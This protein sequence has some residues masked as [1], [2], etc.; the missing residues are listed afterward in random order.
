MNCRDAPISSSPPVQLPSH[1]R[2]KQTHKVEDQSRKPS[3]VRDHAPVRLVHPNRIAVGRLARRCETPLECD[4]GEDREE[5]PEDSY[6]HRAREAGPR[7]EGRLG[8]VGRAVAVVGGDG[9][10]PERRDEGAAGEE[11]EEGDAEAGRAEQVGEVSFRSIGE[12]V[13]QGNAPSNVEGTVALDKAVVGARED[14]IEEGAVE[15]EPGSE[16]LEAIEVA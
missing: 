6:E 12:D 8:L 3:K 15:D 16:E 5:E 1:K 14:G 2:R 9:D 13:T 7:D 10:V 4:D 11:E